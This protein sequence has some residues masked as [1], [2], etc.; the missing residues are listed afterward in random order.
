MHSQV[1]IA[2]A[3]KQQAI[4]FAKRHAIPHQVEAPKPKK[5]HTKAYA[6]NFAYHRQR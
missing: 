6:D 4:A 5:L 3:T 2:F 1:A